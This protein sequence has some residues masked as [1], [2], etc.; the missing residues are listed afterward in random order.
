M[1][2]GFA[3]ARPP[4]RPGLLGRAVAVVAA[5]TFAIYGVATAS[6]AQAAPAVAVPESMTAIV[7]QPA[8]LQPAQGG[9]YPVTNAT[10]VYTDAT[11]DA[12]NRIGNYLAGILR[13]STGYTLPVTAI[14]ATPAGG[15][16]LLL[17]GADDSVGAEG[18]QLDTTASGVVIRA[19]QPAGLFAGVQT[20]RQLLPPQ[21][22]SGSLQAVSWTLP[23]VHIVD[24]PRF[25]YRGAMLDVGRH[26][27]TVS[28]V[29]RYIDELALYKINYLHLHLTDDQG[30]RLAINGWPGLTEIGATTG[31]GGGPGGYYTQADYQSIVTYAAARY[32]TIVPEID[33]PGHTGAALSS[34]P[35]LTC[36]GR[37]A[38]VYTG[39]AVGLTSLCMTA[40]P[41]AEAFI[42]DVIGQ[43]AAL[44]PGPYIN[45]G[46]D[47]SQSTNAADYAEFMT[48]AQQDV[49][50]HG[51]IAIGWNQVVGS[52]LQPSTIAVD[53]DRSN[54][55]QALATAAANGTGVILAPASRAYL[56]QKYDASTII[57]L[58]WAAIIDVQAAYDWDPG[59][60]LTG[61]PASAI[62]GVEAPLW[63]ET[64]TTPQDIDYLTFPRLPAYAEL[65]W[66]PRSTHDFTGFANRLAA[67]GPRW[68]VLGIRYYHSSQITWPAGPSGPTGGV[69]SQ[70]GS[71]CVAVRGGSAADRAP[72]EIA[73]C[74]G[75]AN[76]Q[77]T[78]ASDGTLRALG[79]CLDVDA[80]SRTPGA[81]VQLYTCNGT[82]AQQWNQQDGELVNPQSGL[83]LNVST[84]TSAPGSAL[85]TATCATT[86]AQWFTVPAGTASTGPSGS[87][88]SLLTGK[89][90][91][92]TAGNSVNGTAIALYDCNHT[93]AQ[94][95]TLHD[96]GSI[97]ALGKCLDV[98]AVGTAGGTLLQLWT[99]NGTASQRW[100]WSTNGGESLSN[101]QSG[102]C[103]DNPAGSTAN[104]TRLVIQTCHD[105]GASQLWR[106]P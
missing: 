59:T 17:S 16:A 14:S 92:V 63:T 35:S 94:Q 89:C 50:Q 12:A 3:G 11:S 84:G 37:A 97:R 78:I 75:A 96:D 85:R 38:P 74:D 71:T 65:G 33:M 72:V 57:G 2:R 23:G 60:F 34:Y 77:W 4:G 79:K 90:M 62:R 61:A 40:K 13:P 1:R 53:W 32:I 49:V 82:G 99:C 8:L 103:L 43:V 25:G 30:W 102:K 41:A 51:K 29:K 54:T 22:E 47:E 52:T 19:Q 76:Q 58:T 98:A 101:L 100:R 28:T 91:D 93:A 73:T 69:V 21:I 46:G 26:F 81:Q 106:L 18:Y 39:I 56:D 87:V 70:E 66:S 20:L 36:S 6:D 31:V 42:D 27:S 44:T 55:N 7:P 10:V 64:V 104:G 45:I 67:Q 95:W 105:P 83:C 68:D 48:W 24:H 80:G 86:R 15:I 9:S 88:N 5:A